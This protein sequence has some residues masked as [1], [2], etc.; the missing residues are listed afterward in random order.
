[1]L[2]N[3]DVYND[4]YCSEKGKRCSRRQMYKRIERRRYMNRPRAQ[5]ARNLR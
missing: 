3:T 1:M 5:R 4:S 2:R